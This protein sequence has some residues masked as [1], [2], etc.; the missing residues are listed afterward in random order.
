MI[1]A[2]LFFGELLFLFFLS[3]TVTRSLSFLLYRLTRSKKITIHLLAFLFFPGTAV[4]ELAHA[5]TAGV[6]GVRVGTIEFVPVIEGD[7]VKLGSV[8]VAQTD[9]FRRF[10]IGAAPFF[11]G[12]AIIL[13]LLYFMV[14]N[15]L[16]HNALMILFVGYIVFEIGNTMFSSRKDMEG[17]LE[18]FITL[19]CLIIIFY[20]L[21]VR[22]PAINPTALFE[23]PLLM[24]MLTSGSI[25]LAVPILLD[26]LFIGL[27]KLLKS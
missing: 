19:T 11:W 2:L 7:H 16:L 18:L 22:L 20:F 23:R 8:Q 17:A 4:H 12:T 27:L 14:S 25:Y 21:G 3:R 10:L 13:G 1:L 9:F 26:L 6:L 24:S 5:I 15:D